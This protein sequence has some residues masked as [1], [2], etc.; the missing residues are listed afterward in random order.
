MEPEDGDV[1]FDRDKLYDRVREDVRRIEAEGGKSIFR[2][3]AD[4]YDQVI[5]DM[6]S[7]ATRPTK[8][9]ML[10]HVSNLLSLSST[11]ALHSMNVTEIVFD[12]ISQ[13]EHTEDTP[14]GS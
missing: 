2:L 3:A 8:D 1:E 14:D 4:A 10:A 7:S 5:A 11:A 9:E 12:L 6:V 13:L